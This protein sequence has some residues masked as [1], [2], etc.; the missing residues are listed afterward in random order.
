M[1]S[2]PDID[3]KNDIRNNSENWLRLAALIDYA[4]KNL[5]CEILHTKEEMPSDGSEL[6]CKLQKY[7]SKMHFQIHKEILCPANEYIDKSQF[8]LITYITVIRLMF[9][10][11]YKEL[12][13]NVMA[14]RN[15]I[16]HITDVSVDTAEFERLWD[17]IFEMFEKI[18]KDG[19][20]IKLPVELKTWDLTSV[21]EKK[22][23]LICFDNYS[24]TIEPY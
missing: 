11:K 17:E 16:F 23:Y 9:G 15:K 21:K 3:K 19:F 24:F 2:V 5:C 4:A 1:I 20:N 13:R 14:M 6:Y 18:C 10:G 12:L 8:D 7:K 22:R